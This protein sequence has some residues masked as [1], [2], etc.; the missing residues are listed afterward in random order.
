MPA[1]ARH[2]IPAALALLLPALGGCSYL[3]F[4]GDEAG[5]EGTPIAEAPRVEVSIEGLD[6]ERQRNARA[7]LGL[8][9]E[10]CDAPQWR[11]RRRF[12]SAEEE[13]ARGLRAFGHYRPQ[14]EKTL[15]RGEACWQAAF[16]VD[17][18]PRVT[19]TTVDVALDGEAAE[20][21]AFQALLAALPVREGQPLNHGDYEAAK[22]KLGSLASERGYRDARL[23]RQRLVVDPDAGT[24]RVEITLASG[25]RYRLGEL[26]IETESLDVDLVRRL[27]EYEPGQ[28]YTADRVHRMNQALTDS[29]YFA[30]V[31]VRPEPDAAE[32]LNIPVHIRARDRKRHRYTA[33]A[34]FATDTGPR[35]RLGYENRRINRRGHRVDANLVASPVE[36][37]FTA[38]YRIPL[39]RPQSEW[40]TFSARVGYEDTDTFE[41]TSASLAASATH[42][43]GR[44]LEA[45]SLEYRREN[46]QIGNTEGASGFLL[47]GVAYS[48]TQSDGSLRPKRGWKLFVAIADV[49]AYVA[50][51]S[52]L[53]SEARLRGNS[54]YFPERVIPMLPEALSNG[55]CSL[56]P[57]EDR[58]CMVCEMSVS[59]DGRVTRTQFCEAVMRSHARLTY[60]EVAEAVVERKERVRRRHETVVQHLDEL[61]ALYK[62]L[63]RARETRGA[64]DLDSMESRIVF[65][66]ARRIDRIE[67]VVR[68]DAHRIIEECMVAANVAAAKFLTRHK[69]PLLY[70]VHEPPPAEKVADLALVLGEMG[71]RVPKARTPEPADYAALAKRIA[72]LPGAHLLQTLLLRSLSQAVYSP[73][74]IGH[75]GL[76]L[77]CYAHFTSPIRRYP[78]LLVH[79]AIR[80]VLAG[81]PAAEFTGTDRPFDVLG[82]HCSMTERRA[83]DATR[84]AVA[85]LKCEFMMD[86]IGEDFTGL[87]SGVTSFGVFV[88]LNQ[89]YVEGL[90]HVSGLGNDYFHY[91]PKR[92]RLEGE[93]TGMSFGL[94][95]EVTVKVARVD[96]D[97]RK[98]DLELLSPRPR[99]RARTLGRGSKRRGR[100]ATRTRRRRGAG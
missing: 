83:D 49:S 33:G 53:D 79:R 31:D 22:R 39:D 14:V 82:E 92:N 96:L 5:A 73:K 89:V 95:D 63:Q 61:H 6:E 93:R 59:V 17:P 20:D 75:F 74:N 71:L 100:P 98:I 37:D 30:S 43:R 35:V 9:D 66:E 88:Q 25:P 56:N 94:A 41:S 47:P 70:R 68:N 85:W 48:R 24:A 42:L 80:H 91:D 44:W 23:T 34:G 67:P 26:E 64:L 2:A 69:L 4:G 38:R 76:A 12:A 65:N 84:D 97:E 57:H 90:V 86:K 81:R 54:V 58:L 1:R 45:K 10:P 18:G 72:K 8:A 11:I 62:A 27:L 55:L 3:G 15:T 46:F 19:V 13:I 29:G 52:A 87:V 50:P 16:T 32:D 40:L 99:D 51:G 36:S 77:E 21:A 60:D 7:Y 78:D 28:P